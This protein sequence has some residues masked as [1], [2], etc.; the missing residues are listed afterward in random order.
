[1]SRLRMQI[2][3]IQLNIMGDGTTLLG[4]QDLVIVVPG[5]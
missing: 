3:V 2:F 5:E 4:T 1:M